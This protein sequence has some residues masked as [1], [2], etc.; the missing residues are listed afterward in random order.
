MSAERVMRALGPI[1]IAARRTEEIARD[2]ARRQSDLAPTAA[3]R[4]ALLQ[5]SRQES[6]HATGFA[7]ALTYL[8]PATAPDRMLQALEQLGA[9][10]H[11]DLDA[12]DLGSSMI[13]LQYVLE[14]LGSIALEPPSG[15]LARIG[16]K[17]VPLR[18]MVL[19]QEQGHRRLGEVWVPRI[20]AMGTEHQ[21]ARME[22]AGRDYAAIAHSVVE[23][24]L[25]LLADLNTDYAHYER[26]SRA[27]VTSLYEQPLVAPPV[28]EMT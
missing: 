25:P 5:Q 8:G 4:H 3:L 9:R 24:G 19:Q 26:A 17:F 16:D 14:G 28:E 13:G 7:A 1:M 27:F 6:A 22:K 23:A 11:A 18:E 21:R 10:L 15:E 20:A 12:G 2:A